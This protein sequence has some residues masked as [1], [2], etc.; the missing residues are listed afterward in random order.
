[1]E[2]LSNYCVQ[3]IENVGMSGAKVDINARFDENNQVVIDLVEINLAGAVISDESVN[4]NKQEVAINAVYN[5]LK[6]ERDK[7][8]AYG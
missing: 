4:I 7:V 2:I 6:I 5:Y 1:M 3:A 8:V